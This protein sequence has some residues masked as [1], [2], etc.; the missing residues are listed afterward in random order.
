MRG[1]TLHEAGPLLERLLD[2]QGLEEQVVGPASI[3]AC[4][5]AV[6]RHAGSLPDCLVWPV[7]AAAER[8]AGVVTARSH[9]TIDVAAWN[10]PVQGRCLLLFSVAAV[11]PIGLQVTAEQLRRRGATEVHACGVEVRGGD[12]AARLDSYHQLRLPRRRRSVALIGDAA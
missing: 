6:V 12:R 3:E 8:V 5:E 7:G 4:A 2:T 11:S 9:G 10:T 1:V